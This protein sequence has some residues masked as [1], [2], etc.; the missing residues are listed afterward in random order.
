MARKT[1]MFSPPTWLL[2]SRFPRRRL[3]PVSASGPFGERTIRRRLADPEFHQ[4]VTELRGEMVAAALGELS[5]SMSEAAK[6]LRTLLNGTSEGVQLAAAK[7]IL[8]LGVKLREAAEMEARVAELEARLL[9]EE[10]E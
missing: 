4:C 3:R 8:E 2:V 5:D 9:A 7:A 1:T 10:S 6:R